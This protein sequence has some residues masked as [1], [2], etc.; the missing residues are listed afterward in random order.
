L[1]G[2]CDGGASGFD[3]H[4]A[5]DNADIRESIHDEAEAD[6]GGFGASCAEALDELCGDEG[7]DDACAIEHRAVESDGIWEV[8]FADELDEKCLTCGHVK[9][10]RDAEKAGEN[11]DV[12]ELDVA[13]HYEEAHGQGEDALDDLHRE[14]EV[15]LWHPVRNRTADK[16]PEEHREC[17]E[18][19]D[20]S[21][22]F[23]CM[24]F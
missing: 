18:D 24:A 13:C 21:K 7:A 4:Q 20:D 6:G 22:P 12:P 19:G 3:G 1:F 9:D 11:G 5:T 16:G 14:N 17:A 2:L 10:L 8:I 15:A 23:G